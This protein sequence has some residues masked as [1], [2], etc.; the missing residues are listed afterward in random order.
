M[1][2]LRGGDFVE[3]SGGIGWRLGAGLFDTIRWDGR[4]PRHWERHAARLAA[5]LAALGL[6]S[7]PLPGAEEAARLA[8]HVGLANRAG[9]INLLCPFD[10]L[11]TPAS[12]LLLAAPYD[13]PPPGPVELSVFP[14]PH[15][16]FLG[17]HK[18]MSYLPNLLARRHAAAQGRFDA[19]LADQDGVIV[20]TSACALLLAD[21]DGLV[22]PAHPCALPSISL[23]LVAG[24]LPVRRRPVLLD[25]LPGFRHAFVC[26]SLLGMRAVRRI[27]DI[28]YEPDEAAALRGTELIL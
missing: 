5:S 1:I 25:D 19:V 10:T 27:G 4:E 7:L 6:S 28:A 8:R 20:E 15:A 13:A 16:S 17:R 12:P 26:N 23:D 18:T 11:E 24:S 9:R 22:S 3:I 14:E 2:A 21:D